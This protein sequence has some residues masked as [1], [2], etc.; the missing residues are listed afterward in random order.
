[1]SA[2]EN[3]P[4]F[5][6]IVPAVGGGTDFVDSGATL[7]VLFAGQAL[8]GIIADPTQGPERTQSTEEWASEIAEVCYS[9]ADAM[10]RA[11][12]Q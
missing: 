12:E 10:L 1:M 2:P 5:P 8:S 7:R 3:P 4:A 11:R 9:V 6:V